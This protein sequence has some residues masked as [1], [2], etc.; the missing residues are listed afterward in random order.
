MEL[1]K[2]E[3]IAICET[4]E[5]SYLWWQSVI[6][7]S[8]DVEIFCFVLKWYFENNGILDEN[9]RLCHQLKWFEIEIDWWL[10]WHINDEFLKPEYVMKILPSINMFM[11]NGHIFKS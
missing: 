6:N 9:P 2:G 1:V 11:I 4:V 3:C 7:L 8:I 5:P 10:R